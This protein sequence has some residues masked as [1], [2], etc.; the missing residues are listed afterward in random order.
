MS[1]PIQ[2]YIPLDVVIQ[3]YIPADLVILWYIPDEV[4][5]HWYIP[6][7]VVIS[8]L[9]LGMLLSSVCLD[10]LAGLEMGKALE[11]CIPVGP[12]WICQGP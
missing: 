8:D 5:V 7:D 6:A 1:L 9:F 10:S 3:W 2:W 12:L 4:V 11:S